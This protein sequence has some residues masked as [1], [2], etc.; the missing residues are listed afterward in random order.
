[1]SDRFERALER[2]IEDRSPRD[3]L[4]HL[5]E[6]E[7]RMLRVAQLLR[8]ASPRPVDPGFRTRV[9][10]QLTGV[11]GG[12]TVSR[13]SAFLSGLGALAAGV[14]GGLGLGRFGRGGGAHQM[15]L[16]GD[17]GS[18]F[19]VARAADLGEGAMRPFTA[20]AIQG[21]LVRRGARI[22][23]MSRICT[24]MGC[25]LSYQSGTRR[26]MCPCHGAEFGLDG[27]SIAGPG[28]YANPLP[29]LPLLKVRVNGEQI[30]VWAMADR[31]SPEGTAGRGWS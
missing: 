3:D 13:R 26:L 5:D 11:S 2:L 7:Q 31:V 15:A 28:G 9:R 1:M 20:G 27:R 10:E 4:A 16:V 19:P 6:S 23:A 25:A 21:I 29:P 18:W 14:I 24:H 30:E 17:G 8:G 22:H 12:P